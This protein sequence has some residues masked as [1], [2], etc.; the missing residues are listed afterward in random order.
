MAR[1]L[2][3]APDELAALELALSKAIGPMARML[4]KKEAGRARGLKEFVHALCENID[5]LEQR[6]VFMAA[7]R[8]ALH[9]RSF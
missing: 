9:K 2:D 8:R 5:N 4:V 1:T 3:V 7:A 6:D